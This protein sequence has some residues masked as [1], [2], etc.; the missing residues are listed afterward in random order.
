MRRGGSGNRAHGEPSTGNRLL[1]VVSAAGVRAPVAVAPLEAI[2]RAVLRAERVRH[3]ML[4]VALVSRARIVALNAA[5]LGRRAATDVIAFG[6]SRDP[7]GPVIGDVYLAPEVAR[8]N[9]R[10]LGVP[11]REEILRLVVHGVLHV[12]G[13][14]H[15]DGPARERSPMWRRQEALL[16]RALRR[17]AA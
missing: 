3:A 9:A 17:E 6:F 14:D 7:R 8:L 16:A 13:Y 2:A 5:H 15:P 1:V 4:S 12:L 10:R 11:V